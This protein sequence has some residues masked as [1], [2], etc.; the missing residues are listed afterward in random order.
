[1]S[2]VAFICEAMVSVSCTREHMCLYKILSDSAVLRLRTFDKRPVNVE[3]LSQDLLRL[4]V[5]ER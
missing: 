2:Q 5:C 4:S 3:R 1:M